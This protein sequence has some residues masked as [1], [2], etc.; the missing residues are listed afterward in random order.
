MIIEGRYYNSN[1]YSVGIVAKTTEGIDWAAYIGGSPVDMDE[2]ESIKFVADTGA[3][4]P[5]VD[6]RHYFPDIKLR[7]RS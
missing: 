7:Y 6:A 3:K 5:E 1:G 2:D 4:L